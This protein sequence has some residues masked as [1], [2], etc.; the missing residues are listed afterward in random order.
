M[1]VCPWYCSL[2]IILDLLASTVYDMVDLVQ[3]EEVEVSGSVNIS[4]V[5]AIYKPHSPEGRLLREPGW[6]LDLML[7]LQNTLIDLGFNS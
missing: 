1:L 7:R 2:I 4:K 5:E 6:H 3:A